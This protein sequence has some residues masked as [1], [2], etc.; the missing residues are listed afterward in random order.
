MKQR[1]LLLI[2]A[3]LIPA[4]I[5]GYNYINLEGPLVKVLERNEA[6]QGIQIHSYYYNFIAPSK[7]IFDVMNVENA[8]ASDVFSVLIDFAIVNKD[9]KYQQVILAYKGNAKFILPGDYF[10]KLATN[11]NPSDPSATIKSFIAHVQNLDGANPYSQTTDTDASL[12]AQFDDFN[13]KWY[14]SEVNTLKSDK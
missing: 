10:Q 9:K 11:S 4:G 2:L 14:A 5:Y 13:N 12:Q 1:L 8:S 6:Y 7:V 3:I